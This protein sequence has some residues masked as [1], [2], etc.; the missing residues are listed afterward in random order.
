MCMSY[1]FQYQLYGDPVLKA[2]FETGTHHIDLCGEPAVSDRLCMINTPFISVLSVEELK[3]I[4]ETV[5]PIGKPVIICY[6]LAYN[7]EFSLSF[8]LFSCF[9]SFYSLGV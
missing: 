7:F 9:L 2:C 6:I 8:T 5:C 3:D 1:V 4:L